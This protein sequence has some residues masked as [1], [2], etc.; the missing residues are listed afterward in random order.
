MLKA[1]GVTGVHLVMAG[2]YD[3]RVTE[4]RE[5]YMEL[6]HLTSSLQLTDDVTFIR[7]FSDAQ[8]RTLLSN[9][10]CLLYTP[11]RE[12]FGIVPIESMYLRCPVIAVNTGGPLETV[13]DGETGL[14]CSQ[15]PEDFAN[16]M[17]QFVDNPDLNETMGK[18]GRER[19]QTKFSFEAFTE[20]L[21]GAIEGLL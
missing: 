2:G 21:N 7:S 8:K 3:E 9:A 15:T 17:K 11:D 4:N 10:T 6:R 1:K 13:S 14:L 20:Q 5:Y 18:A 12:H 16:A 19:V